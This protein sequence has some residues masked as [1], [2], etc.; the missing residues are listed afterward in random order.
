MQ[1]VYSISKMMNVIIMIY[2]YEPFT[3][4]DSL[5]M[6]NDNNLIFR[7]LF[8][9]ER[10]LKN[11]LYIFI[12]SVHKCSSTKKTLNICPIDNERYSIVLTLEVQ[13]TCQFV[14]LLFYDQLEK[15]SLYGDVTIGPQGL[16]YLVCAGLIGDVTIVSQGLHY[17]AC[18][19]A[20]WKRH[21]C[22]S[23]AK[24][25]SLCRC[26]LSAVTFLGVQ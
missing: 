14:C 10:A 6:R 17:L 2:H 21:N 26:L 3:R 16:H 11:S 13:I 15:L 7:D 23:R 24:L 12:V 9:T 4:A 8:L 20:Y 19:G 25:L 5:I 18:S 1:Y 22:T